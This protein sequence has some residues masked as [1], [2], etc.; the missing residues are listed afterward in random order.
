MTALGEIDERTV[1]EWSVWTT[2]ARIVVTDP[3]C[4]GAARDLVT[5]YVAQVDVA[6][7][8]FRSDSEVS[9]IARSGADVHTIS[10]VLRELLEAAML[11]AAET[12]GGVDPTLG[13][14]LT[15]LGYGV[16]GP[17]STRLPD[18]PD[19]FRITAHRPATWRDV[20]LDGR[21]LRLPPG[22]LLDLGATAKAHAADR[23]AVRIAALLGCGVLVS[24]GGDLSRRTAGTSWSRTATVSQ[25][26]RSASP[27]QRLLR[28]RRRCTGPGVTT[29]T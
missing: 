21:G 28:P 27:G 19:G 14:V 20:V 17:G 11:A 25:R 8:R 4:L 5:T 2:T 23:C 22:T 24:L 13:T 10:P 7:S 6:A 29:G 26:A 9:R 16:G 12:G 3:A 1:A 15:H 18:E